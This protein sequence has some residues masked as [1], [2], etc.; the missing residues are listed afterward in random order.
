MVSDVGPNMR[1]VSS[2]TWCYL[3]TWKAFR[4]TGR[5]DIYTRKCITMIDGVSFEDSGGE[6][7]NSFGTH[8]STEN[9]MSATFTQGVYE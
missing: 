8:L 7:L 1:K 6:C 2:R 9:T 5:L 3:Y 4:C